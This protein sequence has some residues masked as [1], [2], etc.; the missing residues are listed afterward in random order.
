M[1]VHLTTRIKPQDQISR[2]EGIANILS[3]IPQS[4]SSSSS[5][6]DLICYQGWEGAE[7]RR[8]SAKG[9]LVSDT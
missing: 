9:S 6:K 4:S 8:Q 2:S 1:N 7:C 3:V 5:V